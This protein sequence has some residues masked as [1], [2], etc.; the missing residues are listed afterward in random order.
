MK[1]MKEARG[2]ATDKGRCVIDQLEDIPRSRIPITPSKL[3]YC[4]G[5]VRSTSGVLFPKPGDGTSV[6]LFHHRVKPAPPIQALHP[7]LPHS[8]FRRFHEPPECPHGV[9]HPILGA[10]AL[11]QGSSASAQVAVGRQQADCLAQVVR[12]EQVAAQERRANA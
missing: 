8:S 12:G 5:H 1:R 3:W 6:T 4:R 11:A 10:D 9:A 2:K 7:V